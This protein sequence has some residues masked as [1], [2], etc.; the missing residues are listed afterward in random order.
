MVSATSRVSNAELKHN[1]SNPDKY[2]LVIL[3]EA[4]GGCCM[5]GQ[6]LLWLF[7][8]LYNST[9]KWAQPPRHGNELISPFPFATCLVMLARVCVCLRG[10]CLVW[11]D[12]PSGDTSPALEFSDSSSVQ[13]QLTYASM[14][15]RADGTFSVSVLKQK[16]QANTQAFELR[17]IYG[18]EKAGTPEGGDCVVCLSAPKD[19]TVLPCRCVASTPYQFCEVI[20]WLIALTSPS[21]WCVVFCCRH[22]CLCRE[23]ADQLR[24]Q[25]NKCPICRA[26]A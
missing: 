18:I 20:R 12:S 9:A 23:C 4:M 2:P 3:L 15:R 14:E 24:M 19:T 26:R 17:A 1:A 7:S 11:T 21:V 6:L 22:M 25:T 5:L 8:R 10:V 13:S 16:I